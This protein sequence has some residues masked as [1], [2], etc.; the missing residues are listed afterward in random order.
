MITHKEK[1]IEILFTVQFAKVLTEVQ[2]FN[3][4]RNFHT[5]EEYSKN[6]P[7]NILRNQAFSFSCM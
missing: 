3:I 5:K 4:N 2:E 6:I 1:K 7:V